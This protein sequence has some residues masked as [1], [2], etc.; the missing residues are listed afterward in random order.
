M[1]AETPTRKL[2]IRLLKQGK[3]P[4]DCYRDKK[5]PLKK[6]PLVDS[7][8]A[9]GSSSGKTPFWVDFLKLPQDSVYNQSSFGLLFLK[10]SGRWF[11]LSFGYG[12]SK[13]D[14]STIE[15]DF[16][17]KVVL[18]AVKADS[19]YSADTRVPEE[20][21]LTKRAQTSVR[22]GQAAFGINP[23]QD[24]MKAVAGEAR[25]SLTFG[26]R[27]AGS[28]GLTV[29]LPIELNA[30]PT[31][32]Q[33]ALESSQSKDYRDEFGWIDRIRHIRDQKRTDELNNEVARAVSNLLS[34]GEQENTETIQLVRPRLFDPE[35]PTDI[36][37]A[38][39]RSRMIFPDL[40]IRNYLD[41]LK[42]KGFKAVTVEDLKKHRVRELSE[43]GVQASPDVPVLECLT[44][45][46]RDASTLQILSSGKWYE[47]ETDL[48]DE[49]VEYFDS[50]PKIDLPEVNAGEKE[51]AYN[52]RLANI[53]Q[54]SVCVDGKTVKAKRANWG[55]EV[56]DI[57]QSKLHFVHVKDEAIS[58]KLSHLFSQGQ[59]SAITFL[60][61]EKF[62]IDAKTLL[63]QES[64]QIIGNDIDPTPGVN[65]PTDLKVTYVVMKKRPV[66]ND[67]IL[68]F[69][70]LLSFKTATTDLTERQIPWQF[71]WAF[72]DTKPAGKKK[73]SKSATA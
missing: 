1:S 4:D 68:P 51:R 12:F 41:E 40:D 57:Y 10:S 46:V 34:E 36:Q 50:A 49:L 2:S 8:I 28:D 69:F 14:V 29:A 65:A 52:Q 67:P 19:L 31:L 64:K 21:T 55:I 73:P 33:R 44:A 62:R 27:I 23:E 3:N 32:C 72:R 16:G 30:L 45:E 17:L 20:V 71:G 5:F 66:K 24:L 43:T 26:R 9:Y 6:G 13:L 15:P 39:F 7:E 37:Y 25:D 38:G 56:C 22:S 60:R 63:L 42:A 47:V 11:A 48:W 70:S 59:N 35:R 54:G 53:W 58:S 18:N 61:D